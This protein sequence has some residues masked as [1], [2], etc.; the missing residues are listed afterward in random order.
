LSDTFLSV[1]TF[2][3]DADPPPSPPNV[4]L[5]AIAN[6][7]AVRVGHYMGAGKPEM[8][9]Q[10]TQKTIFVSLCAAVVVASLLCLL[11]KPMLATLTPD[12]TLQH[13]IYNTLPLVGMSQVILATSIVCVSVLGAQGRYTLATTS[14]WIGSWCVSIPLAYL[15]VNQVG[16]N[17]K[18]PVAASVIGSTL[19]GAAQI[20]VVLSS[21][22]TR[23]SHHVAG[24]N[25]MSSSSIRT[26]SS[27]LPLYTSMDDSDNDGEDEEV[28]GEEEGSS[29]TH[30]QERN[31]SNAN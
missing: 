9:R 6:A 13:M 26:S 20:A 19:S 10:V 28:V 2:D 24:Q 7:G 18:G 15:L 21:D 1:K 25:A 17:L 4:H 11:A 31:F 16:W 29:M 30:T 23:L 3:C 22:W 5:D 14:A 27:P 12:P 8:A